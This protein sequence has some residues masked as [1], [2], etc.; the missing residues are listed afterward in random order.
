[1][2]IK[3]P[4]IVYPSKEGKYSSLS[5]ITK[6][7]DMLGSI[8]SLEGLMTN[9]KAQNDR[10]ENDLQLFLNRTIGNLESSSII[11]RNPNAKFNNKTSSKAILPLDE[12]IVEKLGYQIKVMNI[13]NEENTAA[14]YIC[15]H[16]VKNSQLSLH[17]KKY[18]GSKISNLNSNANVA[19]DSSFKLSLNNKCEVENQDLDIAKLSS[20]LEL[21]KNLISNE[22]ISLISANLER[23]KEDSR[24]TLKKS[25]LCKLKLKDLETKDSQILKSKFNQITL[26]NEQLPDSN[27]ELPKLF[28]STPKNNDNLHSLVH[29]THSSKPFR[30]SISIHIGNN[31]KTPDDYLNF[32][33]RV[34]VVES[35]STNN[36]VNKVANNSVKFATDS[37]RKTNIF[38][39]F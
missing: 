16:I 31:T 37:K 5:I 27:L 17:E 12:N 39:C 4:C 38:C 28:F 14:P 25:Q 6:N 36:K 33:K 21:E 1:M 18:R 24:N 2:N 35:F 30:D 23:I 15:N 11:R 26:N 9:V 8:N 13:G 22:L 10:V 20:S 29:E 7:K 32:I 3:H 19:K 34:E